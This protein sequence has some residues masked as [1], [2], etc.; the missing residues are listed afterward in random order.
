MFTGLSGFVI[1]HVGQGL[2]G[3]MLPT[4]TWVRAGAWLGIPGGLRLHRSFGLWGVQPEM[5][6]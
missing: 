3:E 4:V 2:E 6:A 5:G 1:V